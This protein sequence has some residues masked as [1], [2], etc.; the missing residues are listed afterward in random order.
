MGHD[1][2]HDAT[3]N[4]ILGDARRHCVLLYPGATSFNLSTA[5]P[6]ELKLCPDDRRL[7]VFVVDGTWAT[8]K[9]TVNL[10]DNLKTLKRICF[11]PAQPSAFRVRQQPRPE[12]HSTIEAI[13]HTIDLIGPA[14]GFDLASRAHE[15]L[16]FTFEK[17]VARQIELAHM[18][19]P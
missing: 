11:S 5:I 3:V 2:S 1:Y 6:T 10:S 13:Y 15:Q 7:T 4:T 9:K 14:H 19:H 12:C 17:M 18:K 16:L 8:A